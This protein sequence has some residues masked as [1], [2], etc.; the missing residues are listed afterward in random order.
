M[1]AT[2]PGTLGVPVTGYMSDGT[3][4]ATGQHRPAGQLGRIQQ[5]A[6]TQVLLSLPGDS[7]LSMV[8]QN[9]A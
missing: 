1:V 7:H 4:A 3:P 6:V 2:L 8:M 5:P 9:N